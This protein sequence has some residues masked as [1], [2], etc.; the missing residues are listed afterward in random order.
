MAANNNL[1]RLANSTKS[2]LLSL[3]AEMS[4]GL[5]EIRAYKRQKYFRKRIEEVVNENVKY[6]PLI[7]GIEGAYK[8]WVESLNLVMLLIPGV[9]YTMIQLKI[10]NTAAMTTDEVSNLLQFVK[11]ANKIGSLICSLVNHL[12]ELES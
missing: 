2:P 6:F 7:V 8:F 10:S 1:R 3:S 12:N 11:N 5:V 9:I 4:L